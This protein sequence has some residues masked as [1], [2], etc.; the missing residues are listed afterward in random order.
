MRLL[1]TLFLLLAFAPPALADQSGQ[2]RA[3]AAGAALIGTPAPRLK[4]T[5]LDDRTVDLGKL[6]GKKAVYLKF[7]A[8]WCAP[9]REQ[10]P[11]LEHTWR[12]AGPD[13]EVIAV[14]TGFNDNLDKIRAYRRQ[15]GLTVPMAMDDG[16]LAKALN[17]RVT[18]QHV[19][20]GRDGRILYVGH[21]ADAQLD[22][23]LRAARATAAAPAPDASVP[24]D[25]PTYG[26]GDRLPD[27]APATLE[28]LKFPLR[29]ATTR[30]PTAIVFMSPWCEGY[31]AKS[32]P[33]TGLACRAAREGIEAL[34]QGGKVR[35]L[36]V[37]SGLW[38]TREDLV[39][40]RKQTRVTVPLT[41]DESGELFRAFKVTAVPTVIVADPKGR[42]VRRIQGDAPRLTAEIAAAPKS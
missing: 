29:D 16:R 14:D 9:C 18:P 11:H 17:L 1:L 15:L 19:V 38:A 3:L 34:A 5:T 28:A 41:L 25:A 26:V 42:I 20:I 10:M 39:D 22:R 36:A 13:L 35:V 21:L 24:K 4:L 31:L 23:A 37:A 40:Y 32:Q 6:Y 2:D 30:R 7:W 27:L 8:T 33:E 12:T